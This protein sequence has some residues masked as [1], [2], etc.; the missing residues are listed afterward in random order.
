MTFPNSKYKFVNS[1]IREYIFSFAWRNN[2]KKEM[3]LFQL[4]KLANKRNDACKSHGPKPMILETRFSFRPG[5]NIHLSMQWNCNIQ[6]LKP[7]NL[8]MTWNMCTKGNK[9]KVLCV[10]VFETTLGT[11]VK[12]ANFSAEPLQRASAENMVDMVGQLPSSG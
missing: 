12:T 10:W 7:C 5:I 3:Q 9:H 1:Q 6:S 2:T 8:H 4:G 11:P